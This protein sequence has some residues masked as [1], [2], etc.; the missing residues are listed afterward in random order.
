MVVLDFACLVAFSSSGVCTHLDP[1]K[2][3]SLETYRPTAQADFQEKEQ[4]A[5][6]RCMPRVGEKPYIPSLPTYTYSA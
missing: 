5:E 3:D 6:K 2:L 1:W 4:I